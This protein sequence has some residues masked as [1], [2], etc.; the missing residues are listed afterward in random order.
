MKTKNLF[1]IVM[2][3]SCATTQ[4]FARQQTVY[5][6]DEDQGV[7]RTRHLNGLEKADKIMGME[8][9][10]AQDQKLGKV[11][12]LA[13]DLQNGRIVEVI[14]AT[15]GVMGMDEKLVAVPPGQFTCDAPNKGLSG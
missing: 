11:K 7:H 2:V 9:K 4:L 10:D 5:T 12:D 14:L 3:A 1:V 8:V 15:G 13:I 6:R